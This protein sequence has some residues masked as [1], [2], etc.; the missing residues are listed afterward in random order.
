M[1][2][3]FPGPRAAR[4]RTALAAVWIFG[5]ALYYYLRFTSAF[6]HENESAF[7]RAFPSAAETFLS[8]SRDR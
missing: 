6:I 7:R 8:N 5:C 3:E 2:S 1:A 4:G